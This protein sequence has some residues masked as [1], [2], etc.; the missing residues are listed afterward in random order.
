MA[1][2]GQQGGTL[3]D[4]FVGTELEGVLVGKT[5][6]LYNYADGTGGKPAAKSLSGYVPV[7]GGGA[8]EFAM[9]LNGPQVAEQVVYRPVWDAFGDLLLSYPSGPTATELGPR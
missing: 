8:I 6:T 1:V 9:L 3:A 7:E 4:A 2:A 5:G